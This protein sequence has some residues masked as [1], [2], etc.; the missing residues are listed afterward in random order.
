MFKNDWHSDIKGEKYN[1]SVTT[2]TKGVCVLNCVQVYKICYIY[3]YIY[4]LMFVMLV[5]CNCC[6]SK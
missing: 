1:F 4:L 5:G 3:I 6:L 2:N